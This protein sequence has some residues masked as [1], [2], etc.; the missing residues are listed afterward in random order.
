MLNLLHP[1]KIIGTLAAP[2]KKS[3]GHVLLEC[4]VKRYT[5]SLLQGIA[6]IHSH[7]YGHCD[8]KPEN[9][10]LVPTESVEFAPKEPSSDIW[11]F[12][13][14]VFEMFLGKSV[15]DTY[16][17]L[18]IPSEISKDG[19][20]FLKGCLVKKATFRFTAEMLLNHPF[21]SGLD[22]IKGSEFGKILDEGWMDSIVTLSDVGN[23]F[24]SLNLP[25]QQS[26]EVV[27]QCAMIDKDVFE[28]PT[29]DSSNLVEQCPAVFFIP[30][31]AH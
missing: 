28:S 25:N 12:G 31:G 20:D 4:D 16:E 5:R 21:V 29:Q 17:L 19:K 13:C 10:L 2:I 27:L 26:K 23:E 14:I 8:L 22:N 1:R 15:S 11:A 7:G 9:V 24:V 6:Y 30:S 3:G 18:K